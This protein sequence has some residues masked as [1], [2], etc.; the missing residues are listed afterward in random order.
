MT[1]KDYFYDSKEQHI[2]EKIKD[3]LLVRLKFTSPFALGEP[4][5]L[6][7]VFYQLFYESDGYWRN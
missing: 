1:H 4:I 5:Y 2:L 6:Y 3:K 7:Q